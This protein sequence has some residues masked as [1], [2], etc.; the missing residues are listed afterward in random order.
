M[1]DMVTRCPKCGVS[2]R[3]TQAQ[4]QTA[5]GSV[6]C[7][8]CLQIFKALDNLVDSSKLLSIKRMSKKSEVLAPTKPT[9]TQH[10]KLKASPT[11]QNQ[12]PTKPK[13]V[14]HQT[15]KAPASPPPESKP[16]ESKQ[17]S[18]PPKKRSTQSEKSR[19]AF[20]QGAIDSES[21]SIKLS[22]IED[23]GDFLISDD[24]DS[25][26][27]TEE[28]TQAST[29]SID[30]ELSDSFLEM[31]GWKPEEKSLFEREHSLSQPEKKDTTDESWAVNLLEEL[32]DEEASYPDAKIK[33]SDKTPFHEKYEETENGHNSEDEDETYSFAIFDNDDND[34]THSIEE[35]Y[36]EEGNET[37]FT[38]VDDFDNFIDQFDDEN[39]T[40]HAERSDR[41]ALINNIE[42]APVEMAWDDSQRDRLKKWLW[43]GLVALGAI[44]IFVQVATLQFDR[45]SRVEPYREWY[46]VF[47][48]ILAC[49]LP[50]M[51]DPSRIKAYNLVVRSHPRVA[52]ALVVD[53]IL[54]NTAP[55][56]QPFPHLL[57]SFSNLSG[58]L[59]SA[60]KFAPGEYL[61]GEL[62]GR[63]HIPS[64]QPVHLSLEIVD[65]GSDAV[66]Y[67][68]TIAK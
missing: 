33:P 47:C 66:N 42:P 15:S 25:E 59:L 12:T 63:S 65:P 19:L 21:R 9:T 46:S 32:E 31:N 35:P 57:L 6:R 16:P 45:L 8:S 48:P 44:G 49:Q 40:L 43:S 17:E 53:T 22:A 39:E 27:D 14:K 60:R 68:V 67:S 29:S 41:A 11:K 3:I 62:A 24:M 10:A 18:H 50:D 61:G 5:K 54:L 37:S 7:G 1:A 55:F 64:G 38:A 13:A 51:T 34:D 26:T 4:L 56:T 30:D 23:D 52:N 2:F 28:N 20:D 58:K 36:L